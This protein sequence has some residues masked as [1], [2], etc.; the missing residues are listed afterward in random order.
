MITCYTGGI[1]AE[2]QD[3]GNGKTATMTFSLAFAKYPNMTFV[4]DDGTPGSTR[5][6]LGEPNPDISVFTNY[7]V[8]FADKVLSPDE[9]SELFE[10]EILRNCVIGIDEMQVLW[11]SHFGMNQKSVKNRLQRLVQQS[12]KRNVSIYY[13]TQRNK[14]VHA[15]LRRHTNLVCECIKRH[16]FTHDVCYDDQCYVPHYVEV[17]DLDFRYPVWRWP[18][19]CIFEF[20]DSDEIIFE[21]VS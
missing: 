10:T 17:V 20:Y 7:R 5:L 9:I 4:S 18:L 11:D 14:N 12:R 3:R 16:Y 13:T 8:G 21:D 6:I 19:D 15:I 2:A 1:L